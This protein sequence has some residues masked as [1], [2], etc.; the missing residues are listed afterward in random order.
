MVKRDG[1]NIHQ[2]ILIEFYHR[3]QKKDELMDSVRLIGNMIKP[4]LLC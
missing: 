3:G 1:K 4:S 2:V